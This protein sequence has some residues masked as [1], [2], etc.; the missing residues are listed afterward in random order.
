M[1]VTNVKRKL[2][3]KRTMIGSKKKEY[4]ELPNLI[5][6]QLDSFDWLLQKQKKIDKEP[7]LKQGL[8]ELFQD[9]FP[10]ESHDEKMSLEYVEYILG[11]NDI[12]YSEFDQAKGTDI[13][14]SVKGSYK[15]KNK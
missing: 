4:C 1:R 9:I 3:N 7:V 6:I 2:K 10:I 11:F 14:S 5:E 15:F 13:F 12:K 8:E